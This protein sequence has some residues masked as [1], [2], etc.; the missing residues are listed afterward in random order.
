MEVTIHH[1]EVFCEVAECRNMSRASENLYLSQ[2]SISK[3]I[4]DLERHFNSHF[5]ERL[6][7]KLYLTDSGE[8]FYRCATQLLK[9][10]EGFNTHMKDYCNTNSIRIGS[11]VTSGTYLMSTL[12]QQ[13]KKQIPDAVPQVF[14]YSIRNLESR[15]SNSEIDIALCDSYIDNDDF[16]CIPVIKNELILVCGQ[17]HPFY[18][19]ETLSPEDLNGQP[20]LFRENYSGTRRIIEAYFHHHDISVKTAWISNNIES[21][22]NATL[23]NQGISFLPRAAVTKELSSGLLKELPISDPTFKREFSIVYHKDKFIP[24]IM[25]TFIDICQKYESLDLV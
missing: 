12:V 20:F 1:L 11:S 10:Y 15:L 25:E 5:F 13:L 19:R 2:S 6:S 14:V 17:E 9:E 4:T 7:K 22:K 24:D 16:I 8:E 18:T 23:A 3:I 21:I